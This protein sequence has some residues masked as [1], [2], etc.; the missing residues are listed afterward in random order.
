MRLLIAV[1]C[2]CVGIHAQNFDEY[3]VFRAAAGYTFTEG[4]VWTP[5]AYLMFSD[6]PANRIWKLAPGE[7]PTLF[8]DDSGGAAG[9]DFDAK[10]LLY[11]CESRA[12]R[13]TRT[14]K[15]GRVEVLADS[16]EG[17]K[18]NAPNGIVVRKDGH[19]YFT[20]PAFG[21]A[22]DTRELDFYGVYH[23]SPK[24]E[25]ELAA[26]WQTRPNGVGLSPDG[27]LLY[28]T[29]SDERTVVV[30]DL[31]RA[32]KASGERVLIRGIT[33]PPDG[34]TVDEKGNL[35]IAATEVEAY[36]AAGEHLHTIEVT[37]KPSDCAFG[38]PDHG[39]LYMSAHSVVY[40]VRLGVKG[41]WQ[42]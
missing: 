34:L 38:D 4:L 3:Q 35:Y 26:R 28:V 10:G 25:L 9:N 8:R 37:D 18:L 12:R 23:I 33:G 39:T 7:K 15:R 11:T 13:V 1:V 40:A 6:V 20:D 22:S 5:D 14:D 16:W 27:K 29:N 19:V 41:A 21:A 30:F 31:D 36:S 42:H 2:A 32:G 17:K 24:G